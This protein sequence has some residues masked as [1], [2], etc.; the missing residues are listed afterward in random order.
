MVEG[1]ASDISSTASKSQKPPYRV[2]LGILGVFLV[3]RFGS[4]LFHGTNS[5]RLF[6]SNIAWFVSA[7]VALVLTVLTANYLRHRTSSLLAWLMCGFVGSASM[8]PTSSAL[9]MLLGFFV[10]GI[11]VFRESIWAFG[12]RG[13]AKAP[14]IG[15]CVRM[16]SG[17]FLWLCRILGAPVCAGIVTGMLI[18]FGFI[19]FGQWSTRA[20]WNT[21]YLAVFLGLA[22]YFALALRIWKPH[23][24]GGRRWPRWYEWIWSIP[25]FVCFAIVGSVLGLA[26]DTQV[27]K[28]KL[29][30]IVYTQTGGIVSAFVAICPDL[31]SPEQIMS[32]P[33]LHQFLRA[34]E[35]R[36]EGLYVN[37][38]SLGSECQDSDIK[39]VAGFP[40]LG[41]VAIPKD[42]SIT[43]DALS[44]L[45][46]RCHHSLHVQKG[47]K[48]T[49]AG[50]ASVDKSN[51]NTIMLN[52]KNFSDAALSGIEKATR[53][54]FLDLTGTNVTS[55]GLSKLRST[56]PLYSIDL[57]DS[58]VDDGVFET[59][60]RLPNLQY[61]NLSGTK[62][63]GKGIDKLRG[64]NIQYLIFNN[65]ELDDRNLLELLATT[66][67]DPLKISG[68]SLQG[69]AISKAG[70]QAITTL[71]R[72]GFLD[73]RGSELN[74]EAMEL[75]QGLPLSALMVD[76]TVKPEALK[77]MNWA[78]ELSLDYDAE[79][80]PSAE[81]RQHC[82]QTAK[83][84]PPNAKVTATIQNLVLTED[85]VKNVLTCFLRIG[86]WE[87]N[88]VE[89]E[90]PEQDYKQSFFGRSQFAAVF[91]DWEAEVLK[92][93]TGE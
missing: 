50:V 82:E 5:D 91:A 80:M 6:R 41:M 48:I 71:D 17:F 43:D 4:L 2:Y 56:S 74:Q 25:T 18:T 44:A 89:A 36:T 88:I 38:V 55:E 77:S 20:A 78:T 52:G 79:V 84:L 83:L 64:S 57:S 45:N 11:T 67:G 87:F 93:E 69:V 39:A 63:T 8:L 7:V 1:T 60:G 3:V 37:T 19:A 28:S 47:T 81:I 75:L 24:K 62:V 31:I 29:R 33:R 27:R 42:S 34:C 40:L 23:S 15:S 13:Y 58:Q 68:L 73:L 30:S 61:V 53:L 54:R 32:F 35:E 16:L 49:D 26:L 70:L 92:S 85:N 22:I 65:S 9:G 90:D 10:G 51:L 66:D 86:N 14:W 76:G 21:F 59:L 46:W 12:V 72:L